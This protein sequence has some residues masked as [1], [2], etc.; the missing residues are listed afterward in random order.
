MILDITLT[1]PD[2]ALCIL[3]VNTLQKQLSQNVSFPNRCFVISWERFKP[4]RQGGKLVGYFVSMVYELKPSTGQT[5]C[6]IIWQVEFYTHLWVDL[7]LFLLMID[8]RT[9]TLIMLP[10]TTFCLFIT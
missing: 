3:Y 10:L 2:G 7:N 1:S 5:T 4:H 9:D 6:N 8:W